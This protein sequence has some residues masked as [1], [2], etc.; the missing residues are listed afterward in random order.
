[1]AVVIHPSLP[2][3]MLYKPAEEV[4][5][6]I[7]ANK[8]SHL[9]VC[10]VDKEEDYV[11]LIELHHH[12]HEVGDT[13]TISFQPQLKMIFI[14]FEKTPK[15]ERPPYNLLASILHIE[16]RKIWGR[17]LVVSV[18]EDGGN[19]E[20]CSPDDVVNVLY[21]RAWHRGLYFKDEGSVPSEVEID[22]RWIIKSDG[23]TC[24]SEWKK[25][26][27]EQN[28]ATLL[29]VYRSSSPDYYV[30]ALLGDVML[31]DLSVSEWSGR[32]S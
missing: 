14:D 31:R 3:P 10:N 9:T 6:Y 17:A 18:S 23:T 20:P 26:R 2:E 32:P 11:T 22:N 16:G 12:S 1:M 25:A 7:S 15:D 30:F 4:C 13:T 28:G 8:D 29:K 24:I 21:R 27:F 19:L 5:M